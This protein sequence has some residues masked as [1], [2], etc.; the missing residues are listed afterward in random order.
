MS[1]ESTV[2]DFTGSNPTAIR[3]KHGDPLDVTWTVA[4]DG[5]AVSFAGASLTGAVRDTESLASPVKGAT[6]LTSPAASKLRLL[7][8]TH[9]LTPGRYWWAAKAVLADGT[10]LRGQGPLF[11]EPAGV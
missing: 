10:I 9:A 8:T 7:N 6:T 5:A 1:T 11:V 2:M 4:I 3:I